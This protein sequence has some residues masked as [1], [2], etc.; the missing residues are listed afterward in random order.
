MNFKRRIGMAVLLAMGVASSVEAQPAGTAGPPRRSL[1]IPTWI[2]T[3]VVAP[4]PAPTTP[5][6]KPP[7][8]TPAP[9]PPAPPPT[10]G[11]D[12]V[13]ACGPALPLSAVAFSLDGKTLAVG[14]YREVLL[15]DLVAGKLGARIGAGQIGT[16]VRAV[17]FTKDGKRLITAEGTPYA[18]GGVKIFD[19]PGGQAAMNFQEPKGA[20]R[21]L[22][23][24]P[25]GKLLAGGC[26]D[27]AAY[28]WSLPEKKLVTTLKDHALPVSSLSFSSDGKYLATAS[29][30][31]TIQVWEVATW[32]PDD[33][34]KKTIVEAPVRCCRLREV[35]R[36]WAGGGRMTFVFG[37]VVGGQEGRLLEYRMDDKVPP[38]YRPDV[39]IDLDAGIPLDCVW[40][41]DL[42]QSKWYRQWVYVAASDHTVKSYTFENKKLTLADTLTGHSDWVHALAASADGKRLASAGGDGSVKLWD[43]TDRSL[44]ATLVQLAPGTDQWLVVTGQGYYA[45]STPGAVAWKTGDPKLPQ[46][47]LAALQNSDLVGQVLAGKKIPQA[48]K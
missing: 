31:K 43:L 33:K 24:S 34:N 15:W 1:V 26:T 44:L 23:L 36:H 21:S 41:N 45:T 28:V 19:L 9:A 47:K 37:L 6:G 25:D 14:G 16:M 13:V 8:P 20:V 48:A 5:T 22:D 32:K 11:P 27:G 7:A 42:D 12:C 10:R 4:A 29:L 2:A 3:P 17:L 18:A 35:G 39:K 46:E 30:D 40:L 38:P